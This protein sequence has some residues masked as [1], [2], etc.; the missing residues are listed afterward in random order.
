MNYRNPSFESKICAP[1][2]L[3][4]RLAS[5]D[6]PLVFTNGVFDLLHRGHATYLDQARALGASLLVALN[7]D[8]SAR[9]LDKGADRPVNT[10]PDRAAVIAA[11]SSVSMVTW[12]DADTPLDLI[13]TVRP[14]VLVKGGDWKPSEMVGAREVSSWNGAVHSIPFA[15]DR[16]T[17]ATFKR[18]RGP[19]V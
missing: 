13:M 11:L 5:I 17:T 16:S 9:R 6:R 15:F 2:D 12:F 10:L 19:K 3:A 7:G 1:G 4:V 18:I 14:E 8:A